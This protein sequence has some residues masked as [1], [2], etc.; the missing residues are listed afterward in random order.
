MFE[1]VEINGYRL[2]ETSPLYYILA[3]H[4]GPAVLRPDEP[5]RGNVIQFRCEDCDS[6]AGVGEQVQAQHF[7]WYTALYEFNQPFFY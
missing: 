7:N 5:S 3:L 4:I 2:N 1:I 6:I